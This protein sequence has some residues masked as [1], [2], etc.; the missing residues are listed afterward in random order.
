MKPDTP[1]PVSGICSTAS[2]L[3]TDVCQV[4]PADSSVQGLPAILPP[5]L[6]VCRQPC[7]ETSYASRWPRQVT[8]HSLGG[9]PNARLCN[10]PTN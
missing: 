9:L 2:F 4:L 8:F 1:P 6:V 7:E 10:T 5:E 3:A